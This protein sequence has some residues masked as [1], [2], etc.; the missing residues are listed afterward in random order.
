MGSSV[1]KI[2]DFKFQSLEGEGPPEPVRLRTIEMADFRSG[3]PI[4][5]GSSVSKISDFK[6]QSLE[7][8]GPPEPVRLR[9]IE[10]ADFRSGHPI[11]FGSSVSKISD[12][13]F[14][15]L[16][17]EGPPEPVRLRTTERA[18]HFRSG[19][20]IRFGSSVS[21]ISD[22]KFRKAWRARGLPSRCGC[23][24]PKGPHTFVRVIPFA[25]DQACPKSRISN[26]E[27]LGGRGASRAGAV[28]N[29]RKGR[30]LSFGS[31]H[32]LWIKRVQNLGF[33]ISKTLE[34]EGPPEPVRLRTIEMA[35]FRS[36]H[37]IRFGSS[38]SKIS[39]F[40]FQ[41]PWRARGLPS[42]CG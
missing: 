31:S 12:F 35:D 16:E 4:R 41:K 6:F 19:H 14:Q 21:K 29:D 1:S 15:S 17:G 34:G 11:R 27:K 9:T 39:D 24:R 26:F 22:F 38:V 7:G 32:S 13:K 42:R 2:S 20:P 30:T 18:A 36:G 40:K 8:E 5:F 3:H 33:Q 25:L 10:M 37:P 28:A 23:E